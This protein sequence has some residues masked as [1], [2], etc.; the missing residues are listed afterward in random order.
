MDTLTPTDRRLHARLRSLERLAYTDDVTGLPNRRAF[1]AVLRCRLRLL[2]KRG[3]RFGLVLIDLDDF[4]RFNKR[5]GVDAGSAALQEYARAAAAVL[6]GGDRRR[7]GDDGH[8]ALLSRVSDRDLIF[9]LHGDEFAIIAA[10]AERATLDGI[11][12]RVAGPFPV[13]VGQRGHAISA[14]AAGVVARPRDPERL[15]GIAARR[16]RLAKSRNAASRIGAV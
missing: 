13:A 4:G 6:R 8:R 11:A 9:R 2:E 3:T 7:N 10:T 15:F 16:L 12:S 5:W 1:Q 14:T